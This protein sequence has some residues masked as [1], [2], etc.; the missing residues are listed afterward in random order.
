GIQLGDAGHAVAGVM[1]DVH[2]LNCTGPAL[3]YANPD[4]GNNTVRAYVW[5][6]ANAF[7]AG[8]PPA[9][10]DS[11]D[12]TGGGPAAPFSLVTRPGGIVPG[13]TTGSAF[14]ASAPVGALLTDPA[15][16]R[17]YLCVAP[18]V[19]KSVTLS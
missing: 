6:G 4:N 17:L 13:I 5:S 11:W 15:A 12:V 18:G 16:G 7:V 19:W 1:L 3:D 14:P 8:S 10:T 9:A 2:F